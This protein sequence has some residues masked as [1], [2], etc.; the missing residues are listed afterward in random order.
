MEGDHPFY[1]DLTL[2]TSCYERTISLENNIYCQLCN[3]L[4]EKCRA[5]I[6][7]TRY[8]SPRSYLVSFNY[9]FYFINSSNNLKDLIRL[10]QILYYLCL[11]PFL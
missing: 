5:D 8:S 2:K 9:S 11:M 7:E 1:F 6:M 3:G 4:S 10:N